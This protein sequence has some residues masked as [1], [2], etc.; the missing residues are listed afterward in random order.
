MLIRRGERYRLYLTPAQTERLAA[1]TGT[2]RWLWNHAHAER[3]AKL[4]AGYVVP[5]AFDQINQLTV[6]RAALP[7]LHDV[8]RDVCAQTLVELDKAWQRGFKK[9]ARRP[10]YK[11]KTRGDRAPLIAPQSFRVEGTG[12]H[13]TLVFPKI[14]PI[15]A[16]VHRPVGGKAKTCALVCDGGDWFACLAWERDVPDPVPS[17]KPAVGLDRGVVNLVADSDGTLVPNPRPLRQIQ[18]RLARA[19]RAVARKKEYRARAAPRSKNESRARVRVA[20]LHQK[21]RRQREA[22]LHRLSHQYAKSHGTLCVERLDIGAMTASARGTIDHPG[23]HVAAKAGLNRAILDGGWY[24]FVQMLRYKA[25]AA[26]AR[27]VEVPAA[28]SSQTCARCGHVS[29]ENRRTQSEF[30]CVACG[31]RANADTNA[32]QVILRRGTLGAEGFGGDA[33]GRPVKKQLRVVRRATRHV[34]PGHLSS[35]EA[36]AFMPG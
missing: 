18:K 34:D 31:H 8:P 5:T 23:T 12:R 10:R 26:G 1:W 19:Q 14:G 3:V 33:V 15:R 13:A 20:K 24:R 30:E 9:L 2:L 7:W 17:T 6:L 32:A 16:I 4:E 25:E 29:A 28:Y 35:V 11:S 27:I 36:P 21:A 22:V